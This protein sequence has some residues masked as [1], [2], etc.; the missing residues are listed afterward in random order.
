MIVSDKSNGMLVLKE[1]RA[2]VF[3]VFWM[4][5]ATCAV[6]ALFILKSGYIMAFA[7]VLFGVPLAVIFAIDK[8]AKQKVVLFDRQENRVT[9]KQGQLPP[10]VTVERPFSNLLDAIVQEDHPQRSDGSPAPAT[11]RAALRFRSS[12]REEE[13]PLRD[14]FSDHARA[15][16]LADTINAWLAQDVDSD[17]RQA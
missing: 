17:T 1:A 11:Y 15:K 7:I 13:I 8:F 9:L 5:F 6:I 16:E 4:T 10:K 3:A 2:D 14:V 12:I